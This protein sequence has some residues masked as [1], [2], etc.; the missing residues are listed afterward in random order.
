MYKPISHLILSAVR[1]IRASKLD[2]DPG[3]LIIIQIA[4]FTRLWKTEKF[5]PKANGSAETSVVDPDLYVFGP[6][7]SG[8][9]SVI[10]C[11]VRILLLSMTSFWLLFLKT[12]VRGVLGNKCAGQHNLKTVYKLGRL[13]GNK[14]YGECFCAHKSFWQPTNKMSCLDSSTSAGSVMEATPYSQNFVSWI[15][16]FQVILRKIISL[17]P[18]MKLESLVNGVF[19]YQNMY[20]LHAKIIRC[21]RHHRHWKIV[22]KTVKFWKLT[23][24]YQ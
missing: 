6:S 7:G 23:F 10:I 17:E 14:I 12:D 18:Y 16:N 4:I 3:I 1:Y 5:E 8:S 20:F 24:F 15:L 2:L 11:T 22:R 13:C 19:L 21:R 9:G